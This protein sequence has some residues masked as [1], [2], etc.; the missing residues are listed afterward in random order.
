M[1]KAE[2]VE[3]F[4][5]HK[6]LQS[7]CASVTALVKVMLTTSHSHIRLMEACLTDA[8]MAATVNMGRQYRNY[9]LYQVC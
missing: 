4:L 8:D 2:S 3:S 7:D 9:R 1:D 6:S 5:T